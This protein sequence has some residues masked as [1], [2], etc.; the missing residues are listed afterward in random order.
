[1]YYVDSTHS[2]EVEST[3]SAYTRAYFA[4]ALENGKSRATIEFN[5]IDMDRIEVGIY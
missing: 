5:S 3:D 1:M 2:E 4:R